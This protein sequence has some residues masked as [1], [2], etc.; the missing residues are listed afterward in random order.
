MNPSTA[1]GTH[2]TALSAATRL[3][4][5]GEDFALCRFPGR[6]PALYH[7]RKGTADE[8]V[9]AIK[10]WGDGAELRFFPFSGKAEA[11]EDS[12]ISDRYFQTPLPD[13]T[14]FDDY[15]AGFEFFQ[16]AFSRRVLRKAILS[17]VKHAEKPNDF[18]PVDFFRKAEGAYPAALVSLIAHHK[19]GIWLGASPEVLLQSEGGEA[20]THSLAA[21][22][23]AVPEGEYLWN[24]KERDE[25]SHV[26][27]HIRTVLL[28]SGAEPLAE[29]G[30]KTVKAGSVVHLRTTFEFSLPADAETFLKSLHP[31]PAIAGLPVAPAVG[32]IAATE[33]HDRGLYAGYLGTRTP[34]SRNAT[35]F[36]L[37]VN[38]RCMRA[39]ADRLALYIGGG[40]TSASELDAEWEE[41]ENKALTLEKLLHG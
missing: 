40:L 17:R 32:L 19:H 29:S 31:T 7:A 8:E 34:N 21:T 28:K 20:L 3:M 9:F 25:Q 35:D 23:P 4:E 14:D 15:A 2:K 13:H 6:E 30:P 11:P 27:A 1:V 38:L 41:T 12:G 18:H 10:P 36:N 39:G 22:R 26:S 37:Y 16:K 33:K 24:K 5:K